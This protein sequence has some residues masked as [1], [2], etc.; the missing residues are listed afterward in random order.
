MRVGSIVRLVRPWD[1]GMVYK[2][3]LGV[4]ESINESSYEIN[5]SCRV[6]VIEHGSHYIFICFK[7]R[8]EVAKE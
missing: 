4:V 7:N 5:D 8:L 3:L 1:Y 2:D 6:R